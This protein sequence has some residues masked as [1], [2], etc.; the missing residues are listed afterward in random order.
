M[1]PFSVGDLVE[2]IDDT[3]LPG[4]APRSGE[5]WIHQGRIY[6]VSATISDNAQGFGVRLERVDDRP[7]RLGWYAW[8][9]RK[10]EPADDSFRELL[11]SLK[12]PRTPMEQDVASILDRTA[13]IEGTT[14]TF[15][16]GMASNFHQSEYAR[17]Y[18]PPPRWV[19]ALHPKRRSQLF[20]R[21][22]M[23]VDP[24]PDA[25]P[26]PEWEVRPDVSGAPR[27]V[28]APPAKAWQQP[29]KTEQW[30]HA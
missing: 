17:A 18:G 16:P 11:R 28:K 10:L 2:C 14:C 6:R 24:L 20:Q 4:K 22:M 9:F 15:V 8:R 26:R 25:C 29:S 1:H 30:R 12:A 27:I 3:P 19:L 23:S 5:D 21:A 7:P 13:H